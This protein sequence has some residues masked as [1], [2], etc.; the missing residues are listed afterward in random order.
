MILSLRTAGT[1]LKR[2]RNANRNYRKAVGAILISHKID[3]KIKKVTRDKRGHY[4]MIKGL[5]QKE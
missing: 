3:S 4:I 5:I 1:A 2:N